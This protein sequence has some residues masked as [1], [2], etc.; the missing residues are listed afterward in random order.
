MRA[1][2][3]QRLSAARAR[4]AAVLLAF[5]EQRHRAVEADGEHILGRFQ[6][7]IAAVMLQIRPEA[8]EARHDRLA[9][10]GMQAHFAR[11]RQQLQR[12][13]QIDRLGGEA[14]WECRPARGFSP[15]AAQLH[16]GSEAPDFSAI[17]SPVSGSMPSTRG[18]AVAVLIAAPHLA[19]VAAFGIIRAA[20]EGA[21]LAELQIE[22]AIAAGG[23]GAR[24]A[25]VVALRE[26]MRARG[27]RRARR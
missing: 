26:H 2:F 13:F 18:S 1:Q 5:G 23:T 7:G 24:I 11:Q 4:A 21:E 25:A 10:F 14:L 17:S 15:F 27:F 8:A 20:D 16:I 12:C 3:L 22:P 9:D 6:R 19:R